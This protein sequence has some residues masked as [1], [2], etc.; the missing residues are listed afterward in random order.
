MKRIFTAAAIVVAALTGLSLAG[1][2]VV[3]AGASSQA[4]AAHLGKQYSKGSAGYMMAGGG[5]RFRYITTTLTVPGSTTRATSAQ[6][7]LGAPEDAV[8]LN[9]NS[10]GGPGSIWYTISYW[11]TAKTLAVAPSAGDQVTLSIYEDRSARKDY[12]TAVDLSTGATATAV[13]GF[14][15]YAFN[16]AWVK[17]GGPT[18]SLA[19]S[20][21]RLWAFKDTRLTSWNGT[22]GTLLGP[23][24][25]YRIIGTRGGTWTGTV[26][27]RPTYPWNNGHNFSV[28]WRAAS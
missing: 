26:V 18:W 13:E 1:P 17:G 19:S 7:G 28:W 22:H 25:S 9:V 11:D 4:M 23:W 10:G 14:Y 24:P 2:S 5:W 3:S 27:L 6:I 20:S 12:F 8:Y 15:P 21:T 16:Q